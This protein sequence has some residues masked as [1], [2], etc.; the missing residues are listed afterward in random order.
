MLIRNGSSVAAGATFLPLAGNQFE[1]L[2]M[3]AL[4]EFAIVADGTANS[5]IVATV[6]SGSDV[7]QQQSPVNTKAGAQP[8][9]YPDDFQL[10]DTSLRGDRLNV[11]IQNLGTVA[12][13]CNVVVR[14]TP[15]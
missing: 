10:N 4:V 11:L 13:V 14:I 3:N 8:I 6:F 5:N 2:P 12:A 1:F 9:I 15:A 7:L